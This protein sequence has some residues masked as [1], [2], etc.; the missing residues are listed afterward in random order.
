MKSIAYI[1]MFLMPC[2]VANA[3]SNQKS[4]E[5][6]SDL[7]NNFQHFTTSRPNVD[8]AFYCASRLASNPKYVSLLRDLLHN[9]FAQRFKWPDKADSLDAAL[10]QERKADR[11]LGQKVLARIMQD[12]AGLLIETVHPIILLT[13]VQDNNTDPATLKKL[14]DEFIKTE[15]EERDIY[16]NRSGRYG[17]M[18]SRIIEKQPELRSVNEKLM[19]LITADLAK[20]QINAAD[21]S[22]GSRADKRAWYRYQYAYTQYAQAEKTADI[23]K[24]K[25]ISKQLSNLARI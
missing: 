4:E 22:A 20:N 3:Q 1:C 8:S 10:L 9:A 15:I 21:A 24:R 23:E 16:K 17:L 14:T 25:N 6:P 19:A 12:T 13:E 7:F 18:I 11:I 5:S 2:F